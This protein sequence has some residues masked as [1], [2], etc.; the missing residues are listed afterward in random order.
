LPW[1]TEVD[2]LAGDLELDQLGVPRLGEPRHDGLDQLLRGRG[3]RRQPDRLMPV[4][5]QAVE[6]ALAADQRGLRAVQTGDLDEPLGIGAGLR[7]DHKDDPGALL[8]HFLYRVLAVLRRVTDV[9]G[10]WALEIAE[11]LCEC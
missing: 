8:D 5:Q 3:T 7:A 10:G 4:E 1:Q 11:A 2:V 6:L 9:V